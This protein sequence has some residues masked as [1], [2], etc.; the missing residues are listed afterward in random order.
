M[1]NMG[2]LSGVPGGAERQLVTDMIKAPVIALSRFRHKRRV[3][4]TVIS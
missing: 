3:Q 4:G 1:T 2:F